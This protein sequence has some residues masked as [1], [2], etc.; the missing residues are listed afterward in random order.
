MA[1]K[2]SVL[3]YVREEDFVEY[4]LFPDNCD[5]NNDTY[6]QKELE[7]VI[8]V[9]KKYTSNYI[10]QKD[11]FNLIVRNTASFP[12]VNDNEGKFFLP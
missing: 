12:P 10:W 4:F 6:L 3:E 9:V 5:D 11:E 2:K 1:C 8:A 7:K